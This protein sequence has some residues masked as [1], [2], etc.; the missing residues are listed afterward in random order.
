MAT[1]YHATPAE[2]YFDILKEGI[3]PGIDG[4]VHLT[5]TPARAVS[6]VRLNRQVKK[7]GVLVVNLDESAVEP[8]SDGLMSGAEHYV[9]EG[10]ITPDRLTYI[11]QWWLNK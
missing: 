1:Y 4:L 11:A 2:N 8:F 5:T 6:F 7:I 3:S 10:P 9:Y